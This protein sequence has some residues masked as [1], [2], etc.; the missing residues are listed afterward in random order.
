MV[1]APKIE[2]SIKHIEFVSLSTNRALVVLVTTDGQVEN[3]FFKPPVG[4]N[5]RI[6]REAANY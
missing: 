6:M 1:L 3:R 5:S 4:L 2:S